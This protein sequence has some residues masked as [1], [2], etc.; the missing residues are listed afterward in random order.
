APARH[1][2]LR[3]LSAPPR[4]TRRRRGRAGRARAPER[5]SLQPSL[6]QCCSEAWAACRAARRVRKFVA[7]D[8]QGNRA[9]AG[10]GI[11]ERVAEGML[12][13]PPPLLPDGLK[14]QTRPAEWG[15]PEK[16]RAATRRETQR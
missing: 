6:Q 3:R 2:L 7:A 13:R 15:S 10:A 12:R 8:L 4:R 1:G 9:R 5:R 14:R 16:S 11:G